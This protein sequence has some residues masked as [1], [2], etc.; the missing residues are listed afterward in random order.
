MYH[1]ILN[2]KSNDLGN[3]ISELSKKV[4]LVNAPIHKEK[5]D[6]KKIETLAK[7]SIGL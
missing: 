6:W 5:Y 7:I 1:F 4:K 3:K 2:I